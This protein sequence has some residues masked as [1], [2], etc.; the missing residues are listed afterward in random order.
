M[1]LRIV[2]KKPNGAKGEFTHPLPKKIPPTDHASVSSF[3]ANF[4]LKLN[5]SN[6]PLTWHP[7]EN[8]SDIHEISPGSISQVPKKPDLR[9]P[10][11]KE[12]KPQQHHKPTPQELEETHRSFM[13]KKYLVK[14]H[15]DSEKDRYRQDKTTWIDEAEL[16]ALKESTHIT[17]LRIIAENK[18]GRAV[19]A[20]ERVRT[21]GDIQVARRQE[22]LKQTYKRNKQTRRQLHNTPGLVLYIETDNQDASEAIYN[23]M[24]THNVPHLWTGKTPIWFVQGIQMEFGIENADENEVFDAREYL[25][26]FDPNVVKYMDVNKQ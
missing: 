21:P 23:Y 20:G 17:N 4:V 18:E 2:Y 11:V 22:Q 12:Y 15:D 14:Y 16:K 9:Q 5:P 19:D 10:I 8:A 6:I 7:L 13:E 3:V 26:Q 1:L 24:K 25:K